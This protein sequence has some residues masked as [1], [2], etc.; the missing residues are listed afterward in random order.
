MRDCIDQRLAAALFDVPV[1]IGLAER[2]LQ[3][4]ENAEMGTEDR[5][6]SAARS[7][8]HV[9]TWLL[10]GGGL[11]AMAASVLIAV[12]LGMQHG[13]DL[14]E[15]FVLNEAIQSFEIEMDQPGPLAAEKPAPAGYPF[16][17]S[18]LPVR[19]T[20]W[21]TLDASSFG[22]SR[23]VVYDLPGPAGTKAALYVVATESIEGIGV[24]PAA[25]PFTTAGC[26]A[27]AWQEGGLLYV[28]VVQGDLAT[29]RAYLDLP[30][31]PVA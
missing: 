21:R 11:L 28:L 18:V 31:D 4:L 24:G 3:R 8:S 1:P 27:S 29:Y 15:Q 23:G 9:P 2:V 30:H 19:G 22:G 25:H 14:S 6:F 13:N 16:S 7:S 5:E 20:R 12:W 26:C 10:V 17:A